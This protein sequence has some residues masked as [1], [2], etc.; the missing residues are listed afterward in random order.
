MIP[1]SRCE[2]SYIAYSMI[3]H[4]ASLQALLSAHLDSRPRAVNHAKDSQSVLPAIGKC[5]TRLTSNGHC[6][7]TAPKDCAK[8]TVQPQY[9]PSSTRGVEGGTTLDCLDGPSVQCIGGC[10][11][12]KHKKMCI[13]SMLAVCLMSIQGLGCYKVQKMMGL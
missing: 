12:T 3:Q 7:K 1:D 5:A 11:R 8:R 4:S 9:R 2:S 10:L 6:V 13:R